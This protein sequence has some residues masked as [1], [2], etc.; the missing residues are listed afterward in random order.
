MGTDEV[1]G[2]TGSVRSDMETPAPNLGNSPESV[3]VAVVV[4]TYNSEDVIEGFF[5]ALPSGMEGIDSFVVVVSDNASADASLILARELWPEAIVVASETNRGYA[6]AINAAVAVAGSPSHVLVLNDDTRL[7]PGSVRKLMDALDRHP[8]AGIAVPR[9]ID[10]DGQLLKSRRRE[11]TILRT[12]GEAL[13]G[14]DRSGWNTSLGAVV[15]DPQEYDIESD[16]TWASGCAWL[17]SDR[18]WRRVGEWDE[19]LFLYS[20]DVD[21]ALRARDAG[22][23]MRFVPDAVVI[24]LV[25]PAHSNPRLWSMSVWNRYRL[26]RRRHGWLSSQMFRLG[27]LTNEALRAARGREVHKAGALALVSEQHRPEEVR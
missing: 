6:T 22:F 10:G 15:Q 7:A 26:Y 4:V 8:D 25:G 21:Y 12:F 11:P 20:E 9:L 5:E 27:L 24:H 16:V 2:A 1:R 3:E 14:G 13:L 19:S 18:C 17:I 23:S